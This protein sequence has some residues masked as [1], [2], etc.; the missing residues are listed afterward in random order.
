MLE[1]VEP[2][3]GGAIP[4]MMESPPESQHL[5]SQEEFYDAIM[6][7]ESEEEEYESE[8]QGLVSKHKV[9]NSCCLRSSD[10]YS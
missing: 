9:C 5:E 6:A 1:T 4:T 10:Y 7:E 8:E 3:L 2:V